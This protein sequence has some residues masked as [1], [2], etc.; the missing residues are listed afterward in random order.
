MRFSEQPQKA[1]DNKRKGAGGRRSEEGKEKLQGGGEVGAEGGPVPPLEMEQE[2]KE[3]V[4]EGMG[5]P[6]P[7]KKK[8]ISTGIPFSVR[9]L[10]LNSSYLYC[11]RSHSS[12]TPEEAWAG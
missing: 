12:V 4:W 5:V 1:P 3:T 8:K 10:R 2:K 6:F 7:Q 11:P 9:L